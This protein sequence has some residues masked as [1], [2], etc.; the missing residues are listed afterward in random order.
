MRETSL[1][2]MEE[3]ERERKA[4]ESIE[5]TASRSTALPDRMSPENRGL[6]GDNRRGSLSRRGNLRYLRKL[7][8]S[9]ISR[10]RSGSRRFK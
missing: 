6:C 8:R 7:S 4:A 2:C 3:N 1:D 10:Y 5:Q 9:T